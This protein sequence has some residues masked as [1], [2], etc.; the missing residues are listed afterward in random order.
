MSLFDS[1]QQRFGS[2]TGLAKS[3]AL[4]FLWV[5]RARQSRDNA[6]LKFLHRRMMLRYG[7]EISPTCAIGEGLYLG[8]AFGITVNPQARIGR[9]CNIHK[10]VTIGRENRGKRCGAPTIGDEVWIGANSTIV[11]A[12]HVG[13][14]V[15]VAPNTYVN[16]DVPDHSIVLGSPCKVIAREH[17]TE[18]YINSKVG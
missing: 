6:L 12:V 9:N 7:I 11:G 5:L 14:D 10:G 18:G 15:L 3:H 2:D 1:D 8:H 4:R 13:S 16:C 17:A